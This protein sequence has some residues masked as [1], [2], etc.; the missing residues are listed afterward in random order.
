MEVAKITKHT[1]AH[2]LYGESQV[3][4]LHNSSSQKKIIIINDS[5]TIRQNICPQ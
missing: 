3:L 4:R 5:I 1:R 2:C